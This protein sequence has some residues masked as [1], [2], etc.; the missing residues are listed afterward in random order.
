MWMFDV[1]YITQNSRSSLLCTIV[2]KAIYV[3][4]DCS[5]LHDQRQT[6]EVVTAIGIALQKLES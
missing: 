2:D 1:D 3:F 4:Y 6:Q 5:E